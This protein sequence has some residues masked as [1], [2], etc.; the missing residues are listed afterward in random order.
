MN[1]EKQIETA[2]RAELEKAIEEEV[3]NAQQRIRDRISEIAAK[4]PLRVI[5][6]NDLAESQAVYSVIV[7]HREEAKQA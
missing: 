5:R 4:V 2:M 1:I 6:D 7:D 3:T